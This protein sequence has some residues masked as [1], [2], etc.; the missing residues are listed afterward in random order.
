MA[1]SDHGQTGR[2]ELMRRSL[3]LLTISGHASIQTVLS[4]MAFG[5]AT[6][7]ERKTSNFD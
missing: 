6:I 5:I 3:S 1:N 2:P 4:A 7:A